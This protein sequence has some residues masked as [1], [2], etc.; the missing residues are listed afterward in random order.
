MPFLSPDLAANAQYGLKRPR[1]RPKK[2]PKMVRKGPKTAETVKMSAPRLLG[3][4]R[5]Q[6]LALQDHRH[7]RGQRRHARQPLRALS[8]RQQPQVHLQ[9][10]CSKPARNRPPHIFRYNMI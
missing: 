8:A 5:L 4:L 6:G 2:R 3:G 1:V 7:G 9:T 10:A